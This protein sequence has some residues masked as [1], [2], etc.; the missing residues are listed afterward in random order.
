GLLS[1]A[2]AVSKGR[3]IFVLEQLSI[4]SEEQVTYITV[5]DTP[6]VLG[7]LASIVDGNASREHKIVGVTGTNGKT[8]VATLLYNLFEKMGYH[9]GLLSTVENRIGEITIPATHT[10]PNP[11]A[12]NSMLRQMVDAGCD[13]CFME[14]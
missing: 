10:T 11:I 3:S 14:V 7:I 12:L 9:V 13:Y 2:N 4:H 6:Y 8:T 5:D 1:I